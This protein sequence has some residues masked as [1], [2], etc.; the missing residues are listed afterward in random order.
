MTHEDW[1]EGLLHTGL[2]QTVRINYICQSLCIVFCCVHCG[3]VVMSTSR[4]PQKYP[5]D[6]NELV[7]VIKGS[8][9]H[10]D[11]GVCPLP[12]PWSKQQCFYLYFYNGFFTAEKKLINNLTK[13]CLFL[14]LNLSANG[15]E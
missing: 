6:N 7:G 13:I 1:E 4:A 14:P 8:R 12:T 5:H 15:E 2:F 10:G 9:V 11:P 3:L